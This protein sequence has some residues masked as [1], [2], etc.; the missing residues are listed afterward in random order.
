M[1]E[2]KLSLT[3]SAV[4]YKN[5]S[6]CDA[7]KIIE[8]LMNLASSNKNEKDFI[9]DEVNKEYKIDNIDYKYSI[10]IFQVNKSV[11]FIK[12][13]EFIDLV[14]AYVLIIE[15]NDYIIIFSK[16][17]LSIS[18]HLKKKFRL[19]KNLDFAKKISDDVEYQK[20]TLRNMTISEKDIRSRAY[21]AQDLKGVLSLHLAGRSIPSY[22][23][24]K[25]KNKK[26]SLS[27]AGRIIEDS[28]R[29]DINS[30]VLWAKS[31]IDLLNDNTLENSFISNFAKGVD[32]NDVLKNNKPVAVLFEYHMIFDYI[33]S[34]GDKI[35]KMKNGKYIEVTGRIRRII[36]NWIE[37]VYNLDLTGCCT[38]NTYRSWKSR[39]LRKDKLRTNKSSFSIQARA[40]KLY[41]ICEDGNYISIQEIINKKKL[42]SVIFNDPSYMYFMGEC[43]QNNLNTPEIKNIINSIETFPEMKNVTS[44]KGN[45]LLNSTSFDKDSLFFLVENIHRK[46]GDTYIFCDDL[47]DEWADHITINKNTNCISFIHS[48]Y[49]DVSNSASNLHDVTG[50]AIKNLGNMMFSKEKFKRKLPKWKN[51]YNLSKIKRVRKGNLNNLG[52]CIDKIFKEYTLHRKCII[53]C[54]FLSK[55]NME[56]EFIKLKSQKN[57]GGHIVQLL[58]IL[59]SFIHAARESGVIPI[60]YCQK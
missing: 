32:L 35:Y 50:Q 45:V 23:K 8:E 21:E 46:K 26:I 2:D 43:F 37:N 27:S 19:I 7:S 49:K 5:D 34:V 17:S 3:K 20:L 54:P 25:E 6:G 15:I 51:N 13:D 16:N 47:G 60:I 28:E 38:S 24:I 56:K 12:G 11:N 55:R 22:I 57:V 14:Y 4:F 59:S 42:F 18:Q 36:S 31:K 9:L 44:E 33:E 41:Y 29:I 40:L 48:K 39:T 53:A 58:W 52:K 30:L 1:F 10:R